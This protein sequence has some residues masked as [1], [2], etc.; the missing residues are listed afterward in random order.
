MDK[1]ALLEIVEEQALML[2][3]ASDGYLRHALQE[4]QGAI[5]SKQIVVIT[6]IRRSGKSTL[7]QQILKKSF[8][9]KAFYFSF[10]DERLLHFTAE[11]F[12]VLYEALVEFYG[13]Q[14]T[15]FLD[16]V[17]NVSHWELFVRRLHDRGMKIFIT[18]SNAT[19]LSQELSTRLTGRTIPY[20]LYPFS[21][22]EFVEFTKP[23]LKE[24]SPTTAVTRGT[25]SRAFQ[26]YLHLGGIPYYVL[27][28]EKSFLIQLYENIL[29]RDIISRYK[30]DDE[31]T[32]RELSLYLISNI[33]SL[34]AYNRL[35]GLLHL[36]SM[37]TVK[38][39]IQYLENTYLFFSLKRFCYS[40]KQQQL[41]PKKIYCIDSALIDALS[42]KFSDN[43]GHL[44]ENI[45]F[46]ELKRKQHE[47]YYFHCENG[48]EVDF[49]VREGVAITQ[50]I[51]V[52]ASINNQDTET[53]EVTAL[54]QAMHETHLSTGLILTKS[55]SKTIK[56]DGKTIQIMPIYHWLLQK[57][58]MRIS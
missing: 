21:F 20:E 47:V 53:R 31:K 14:H 51:Q 42:F 8:H 40:L 27:N 55:V 13:E 4:I 44:L 18:G 38:N 16:E 50:L 5:R 22:C 32:M 28:R 11:D 33:A 57:P 9:G 49:V 36:G 56:K 6:G 35:K 26:E 54:L 37:N 34:Y 19:L 43:E 41:A 2:S 10:E 25:F 24:K 58:Q 17:Q 15:F 52:C 48:Q 7:L 3:S 30:L 29:Y 23:T 12:N 45:V 39:Y 1:I 46:L